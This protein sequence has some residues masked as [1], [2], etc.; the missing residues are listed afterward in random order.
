MSA[1]FGELITVGP[2]SPCLCSIYGG[3]YSEIVLSFYDTEGNTVNIKD[4]DCTITLILSTMD[5]IPSHQ[6]A[7]LPSHQKMLPSH[8][9]L[10]PM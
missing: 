2:V 8:Q 4:S 3:F 10:L 9:R 5:D 1:K 7:M 6:A